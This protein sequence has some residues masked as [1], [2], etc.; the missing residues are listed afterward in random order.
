MEETF[1]FTKTELLKIVNDNTNKIINKTWTE[2]S[3]KIT[4]AKVDMEEHLRSKRSFL[5]TDLMYTFPEFAAI[6]K[7][8]II[9]SFLKSHAQDFLEDITYDASDILRYAIGDKDDQLMLFKGIAE[10][11][12]KNLLEVLKGIATKRLNRGVVNKTTKDK[13]EAEKDKISTNPHRQ[14]FLNFL[15]V[16]YSRSGCINFFIFIF[17]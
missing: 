1:T 9:K 8:I 3:S 2:L 10:D 7:N 13:N 6:R 5:E 12:I 11:E 4:G 15:K 16:C 14:P 17:L